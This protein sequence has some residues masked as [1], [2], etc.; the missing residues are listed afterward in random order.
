MSVGR[1]SPSGKPQQAKESAVD[2]TKKVLDGEIESIDTLTIE[3]RSVH[4]PGIQIFDINR[5]N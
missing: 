5:V 4:R 3:M 1:R 2:V